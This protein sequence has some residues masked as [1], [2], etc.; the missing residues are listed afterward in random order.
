MKIFKNLKLRGKLIGGG[1]FAVLIPMLIVGV[2]SVNTASKALIESGGGMVTQVAADLAVTTEMFLE[3]ELK[4]AKGM[5][6]TPLLV[7]TMN[8]VAETGME[9]ARE[10][11]QALD[12]YFGKVH[13]KIGADY[14]LFFV[15]DDKGFAIS[16]STGGALRKKRLNIADRDYFTAARAGKSIIGIPVMSKASNM[17]VVVLSVPIKTKSGEFAGVF[18]AVLKLNALS[19]KMVSVKIG[20]TG[21][22]FMI[23]KEGIMIAHPRKELIFKLDTKTLKGSET[24]IKDMMAQESGVAEYTFGGIEKVSGFAPVPST[25]WSI[26]VT[27]NKDEFMIS[28]RRS[29]ERL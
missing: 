28:V 29:E 19:Q 9:N 14:D 17:P 2:I 18:G 23:N 8:K 15:S 7:D 12:Q 20:T 5:V 26:A 1:A 3:G 4:F 22:P 21:Y 11:I 10:S 16:D 13:G 25:D 6:M 27:Q 24:I